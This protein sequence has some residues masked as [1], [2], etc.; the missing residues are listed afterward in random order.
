MEY[1]SA[2]VRTANAKIILARPFA[3]QES[4]IASQATYGQTRWAICAGTGAALCSRSII[5]SASH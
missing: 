2:T 4:F 3:D 5:R 1:E